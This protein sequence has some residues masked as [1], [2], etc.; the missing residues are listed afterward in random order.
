MPRFS[1]RPPKA[2]AARCLRGIDTPFS[3]YIPGAPA[4]SSPPL[5]AH[6]RRGPQRAAEC[7]PSPRS[8]SRQCTLPV[9]TRMVRYQ[10]VLDV[11][12]HGET[13]LH[14]LDRHSRE[15]GCPPI[16]LAACRS[17]TEGALSWDHSRLILRTEVRY[18][19]SV[20]RTAMVLSD[21]EGLSIPQV[22]KRIGVAVA[23]AWRARA[24]LRHHMFQRCGPGCGRPVATGS[25]TVSESS[26]PSDAVS[27]PEGGL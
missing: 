1:R 7:I 22:A 3:V 6:E 12:G 19:P 13:R 16:E 2:T 5:W 8:V 26:S 17:D 10:R 25:R 15:N 21:I 18:I 20:L 11:I 14:C 9:T 24:E 23:T 4:L 27:D